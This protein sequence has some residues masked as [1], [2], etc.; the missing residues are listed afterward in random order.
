MDIDETLALLAA[1]IYAAMLKGNSGAGDKQKMAA[2]AAEE[3][4]RLWLAVLNRKR[5]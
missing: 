2:L 5:G 4:Q 3:A 1:P